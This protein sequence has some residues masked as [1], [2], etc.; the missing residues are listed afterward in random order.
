MGRLVIALGKLPVPSRSQSQRCNGIVTVKEKHPRR[1][2]YTPGGAPYVSELFCGFQ[3]RPAAGRNAPEPRLDPGMQVLGE[4][5]VPKLRCF[6]LAFALG[7]PNELDQSPCL[8]RVAV[9]L[10]QQQ[11]VKV[12]IGYAWAPDEFV[13][14]TRKSVF[15]PMSFIAPVA[16]AVTASR[17]GVIQLPELLRS[18]ANWIL[19]LVAYASST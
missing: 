16:A 18:V 10:M 19:L 4:R 14:E 11:P 9:G 2:N 15:G 5:R 3:D 12:E 6:G 8:C 7:P 17:V 13:M 1:P